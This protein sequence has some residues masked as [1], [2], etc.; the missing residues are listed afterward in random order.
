MCVCFYTVHGPSLGN[1]ATYCGWAFSPLL[2][3]H[4]SWTHSVPSHSTLDPGELGCQACS[5]GSFICLA[6]SL[7]QS[8]LAGL[9]IGRREVSALPLRP[10]MYLLVSHL[11]IC[12]VSFVEGPVMC[13]P[14]LLGSGWYPGP[15]QRPAEDVLLGSSHPRRSRP[16]CWAYHGIP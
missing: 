13:A 9:G 11:V 4:S 12:L 15:S 10:C 16:G 7:P 5:A 2:T 14:V 1:G 3:V 8:L 6:N